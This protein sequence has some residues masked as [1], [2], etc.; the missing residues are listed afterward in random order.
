VADKST[1]AL[2]LLMPFEGAGR[3]PD[4]DPERDFQGENGLETAPILAQMWCKV[5]GLQRNL[6]PEWVPEDMASLVMENR[7]WA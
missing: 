6:R 7:W 1:G 5:Q 3:E 2:A 4:A